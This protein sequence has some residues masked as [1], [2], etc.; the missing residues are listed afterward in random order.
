M[1]VVH[2]PDTEQEPLVSIV[3]VVFNGEK[4]LERTIL[5]VLGQT[6]PNIEY[7]IIDGGST[8]GT[9]SIIEKYSSQLAFWKSEADHGI[10]DAMNK[11]IDHCRGRIV[12]LINSDDYYAP[13]AVHFVVDAFRETQADLVFGNQRVI[14]ERHGLEK[15][16]S[17]PVPRRLREVN[18]NQVHPTV[19]VARHLYDRVRFDSGYKWSADYKF[20]ATLFA[21]KAK[22][23]KIE[24]TLATMTFG[25]ASASLNAENLR[26][27]R[28]VLDLCDFMAVTVRRVALYYPRLL[29][30]KLADR[31]GL[32]GVLRRATGWKPVSRQAP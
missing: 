21:N 20:L 9:I 12:G 15:L 32:A 22:F 28:E 18:L 6:Y 7:I 11:G 13:D 4:H 25:G 19:F 26:V 30:F 8:D 14:D 27:A 31:I 2:A 17:L 29:A 10:Y 23:V 24:R 1:N 5:S 16:V 3:T